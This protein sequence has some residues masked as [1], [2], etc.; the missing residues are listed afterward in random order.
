MA[1]EFILF[2]W[3]WIKAPNRSILIELR[4][5][6]R[7]SFDSI[8]VTP[9]NRQQVAAL[10]RSL[11]YGGAHTLMIGC[12]L[13]P[14]TVCSTTERATGFDLCSRSLSLSGSALPGVAETVASA[15]TDRY[16]QHRLRTRFQP[17]QR[18]GFQRAL[19]VYRSIIGDPFERSPNLP[20]W[21]SP[22]PR[23]SGEVGRRRFPHLSAIAAKQMEWADPPGKKI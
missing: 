18:P 9:G 6:T 2:D 13:H 8:P 20:T 23:G 22:R 11:R 16:R 21:W 12:R 1:L 5:R 15:G 14:R 17:N 10:S 3:S 19:P 4:I 7:D